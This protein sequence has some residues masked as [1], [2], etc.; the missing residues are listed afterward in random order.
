VGRKLNWK[1]ID[2][3]AHRKAEWNREPAFVA[4][5]KNKEEKGAEAE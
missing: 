3:T 5:C 1:N 4:K 2:G